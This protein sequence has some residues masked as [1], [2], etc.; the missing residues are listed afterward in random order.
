MFIIDVWKVVT[1]L[2]TKLSQ[3]YL[4]KSKEIKLPTAWYELLAM[5][6]LLELSLAMLENREKITDTAFAATLSFLSVGNRVMFPSRGVRTSL[7][8]YADFLVDLA[9]S[10]LVTARS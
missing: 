6:R 8:K 1:K 9:S 3:E 2:A 5:K 10:G 4:E 7:H